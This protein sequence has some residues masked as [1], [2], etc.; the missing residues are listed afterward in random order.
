MDKLRERE[1]ALEQ[2]YSAVTNGMMDYEDHLTD[3]DTVEAH[4]VDACERYLAAHSEA[5]SWT[6]SDPGW[7]VR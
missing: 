6:E 4:M 1:A 2:L 5:P 7:G 3:R